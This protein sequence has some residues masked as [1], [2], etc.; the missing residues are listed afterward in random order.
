MFFI[1]IRNAIHRS[2]W[3]E[4]LKSSAHTK[5]NRPLPQT[6]RLHE[7]FSWYFSPIFL[8]VLVADGNRFGEDRSECVRENQTIRNFILK[9]RKKPRIYLC[10]VVFT[11]SFL[12]SSMCYQVYESDVS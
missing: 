9:N 3:E 11:V 10:V 1:L 5:S 2:Q 4:L 7:R 6:E 12:S 8:L